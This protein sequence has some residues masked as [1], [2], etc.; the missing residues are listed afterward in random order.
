MPETS[1]DCIVI[2]SGPG[3][4]VAAIRAAQ[5]GLQT[6]VVE[7]S[8][9]GGTCLNLGCIPT[10]A[11]LSSVEALETA[12]RGAEF[13]F[14]AENVTPDYAAIVSR[15]E[16]IVAQLRSG[17]EQLMR[18]RKIAV[19]PGAAS[20]R[21]PQEVEVMRN[22]DRQRLQARHVILATGSVPAQPPIPGA[23]LPGVVNSDGLLRLERVPE[24]LAIVGSGAV[25]L[26]WGAIF[27]ALGTQVVVFEMVDRILPPADAEISAELAKILARRG[28][29]FHVSAT[30]Q[31]IES[32]DGGLR[33]RF[34]TPDR[35][36]QAAMADVVLLATGRV[37]YTEGL[38]LDRVGI[39]LER[40]AIPVDDRMRTRVPG[41]FAIGD[42]VPGPQLAHVASKE[43]EVAVENIA[44]RTARMSYRAVPFCVYTHPEVA[45]VGLTEEEARQERGE[46]R[47]GRF[48][49][50]FLG[51]AL[52]AGTR[53]GLVKIVAEPRYGEVLGVHMLGPHVTDLIAEATLAVA[54]EATVDELIHTI[55]AHPTMPEAVMESA[56]DVWQRAIHKP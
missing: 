48:P 27:A 53:E 11:M 54:M 24:R 36:D 3:G 20:L 18:A 30:V 41:V 6:A 23:D 55:H 34:A 52:A 7:K 19:V 12:R 47:V 37:P 28:F 5:L 31:A 44:G 32:A 43:G 9:L 50:R 38:G 56:L 49:F 15:R 8:A 16:K 35:G 1:Y 29:E 17:V 21:S 45:W 40:R 39:A 2:G 10:K 26:E 42:C 51:R 14:H 46:V 25:G 13:G 33:V 22:G 4:Y